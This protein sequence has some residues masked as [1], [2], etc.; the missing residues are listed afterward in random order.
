MAA[1]KVKGDNREMEI[2]IESRVRK[3]QVRVYAGKYVT[4]ADQ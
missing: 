1:V 3:E 2:K 4:S